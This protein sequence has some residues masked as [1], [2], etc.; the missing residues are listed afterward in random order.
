MTTTDAGEPALGHADEAAASTSTTDSVGRPRSARL[1]LAVAVGFSALVALLAD[2]LRPAGVGVFGA[3]ATGWGVGALAAADKRRVAAGSVAAVL[4]S[5]LVFGGA[6]LAVIADGNGYVL[7]VVGTVVVAIETWDGIDAEIGPR[8]KRCLSESGFVAVVAFVVFALAFTLFGTGLAFE[9]L[10]RS[11]GAVTATPLAAL[12]WLQVGVLGIGLLL[13]RASRVVERWTDA[14]RVA[15]DGLAAQFRLRV[16]DVPRWYLAALVVQFLVAS[17]VTGVVDPYLASRPMLDR[18]VSLVLLSG[19]THGALGALLVALGAIALL[20]RLRAGVVFW[21]GTDP[22]YTLAF[23]AG[24]LASVGVALL[25]GAL[26]ALGI[27][28]EAFMPDV[29]T[30]TAFAALAPAIPV[31]AGTF[32]AFLVTSLVALGLW[33]SVEWLDPSGDGFSIGAT[34]L[35]AGTVVLAGS[36]PALVVVT[37]AAVSLLVWDLGVHATGLDR[38]LQALAPP[39]RTEVVHAVAAGGALAVGVAL[40]AGV[41]YFVVPIRIPGER[42]VVAL[43]LAVAALVAL[44][45]AVDS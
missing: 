27:A 32:A 38:D 36:L 22:G 19:A 44:V 9:V 1:A 37:G 15:T 18:A 40:A 43:A 16:S 28:G 26:A 21:T 30:D 33:S 17:I 31:L 29:A 20:P 12:F 42:A 7:L 23:A 35:F 6:A 13:D 4:G 11:L 25:A 39:A 5:A 14:E 45:Y 34:F 2:G 24:G 10:R 3:I 8:F 41:G